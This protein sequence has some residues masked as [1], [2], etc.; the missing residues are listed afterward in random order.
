MV[1]IKQAYLVTFGFDQALRA[2][3]VG[4]RVKR[5]EGD[6]RV[7]KFVD[8]Y[9]TTVGATHSAANTRYPVSSFSVDDIL[10]YDWAIVLSDEETL[11]TG[12]SINPIPPVIEPVD[13]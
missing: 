8:G 11:L 12:V 2:M 10:A 9:I 1:E 5:V 3:K 13:G 6:S 7:Y 4:F